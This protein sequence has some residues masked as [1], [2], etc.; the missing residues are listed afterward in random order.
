MFIKEG[1]ITMS[2]LST[3][4][5]FVQKNVKV[6]GVTAALALA[7]GGGAA[8]LGTS[9]AATPAATTPNCD[10]NAVV[11]CGASSVSD[12]I[13]KYNNGDGDPYGN[14]SKTYMIHDIYNDF[15][16]SPSDVSDMTTTAVAGYVSNTGDVYTGETTGAHTLVAT[17]ALTAG[18][19][20]IDGSASTYVKYGATGFWTRKPSVSFLDTDLKAFV[21]MK[22]G[23]FQ[24]AILYSCGNPVKAVPVPPAPKPTLACTV[25]ND[26]PGTVETNGD[27]NYTFAAV[28]AGTN[29]ETVT[30]YD[31]NFGDGTTKSSP[32]ATVSHLFTPGTWKITATINGSNSLTASCTKSIT[33]SKP[34]TPPPAG[35]LVCCDLG[36][37]PGSVSGDGSEKFTLNAQAQISAQ[38]ATITGYTFNLGGS[39]G[40]LPV[41]T[42][43]STA[44]VSYTYPAGTDVTA[45]VTVSGTVDGK[46]FTTTVPADSP[47][48]KEV[49]VPAVAASSIVCDDLATTVDSTDAQGNV[50]YTF[51]AVAMPTNATIT[52]YTFSPAPSTAQPQTADTASYTYAPG[53]AVKLNVTVNGKLANGTL[54]NVTSGNCAV[55]FTVPSAPTCTSVSGQT[56]PEGSSE[57][58]TCT[59]STGQTYQ[60]GSPQCTTTTTTTT[61]T[62]TPSTPLPNTGPGDVVGLFSGVSMSGA[63]LHRILGNRRARRATATRRR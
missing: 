21:V 50:T 34:V 58:Q 42:S 13:T 7:I 40:T 37:E 9:F 22:D 29:G 41:S 52:G 57:C 32:T 19:Q 20:D 60:A 17:D 23:V 6:I 4:K 49:K 30:S 11:Y 46:A 45:S 2:I 44:S 43:A 62:T 47:C 38:N 35:S 55:S 10:N 61:P 53:T 16:I 1:A 54:V 18:R 36:L 56:Y 12:L 3:V 51:N 48:S 59:S 39:F 28:A 14:A 24:Y 27:Q 25:L 63:G 31:Y 8:A 5:R 15:R 33:I 26:T